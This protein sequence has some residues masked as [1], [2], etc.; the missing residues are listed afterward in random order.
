MD[1]KERIRE[2]LSLLPQSPGVYQFFNSQG[3]IIYIGKA[4]NLKRRVSSYFVKKPDTPKTAVLVRQIADIKYILVES[5]NDALLLE[6]NL[7]KRYQPRYNLMLKYGTTYPFLCITREEFPRVF[8]TRKVMAG[9][10]LYGPYSLIGN[11]VALLDLI[12]TLYPIRSCKLPLSEHSISQGRY[13]V[14]LEYHIKNCKGVCQGLQSREEYQAM[15]DDIRTIAKGN[16]HIVERYL[17]DKIK[18]TSSQMRFEEA[19]EWKQKYEAIKQFRQKTVISTQKEAT[20]DV[21]SCDSDEQSVYINMLRVV[22]GSIIQSNTIEYKKNIEEP[23]EEVFSS[24]IVEL[25]EQ[26][27][28]QAK[29]IVVPF[30]PEFSIDGV[31]FIVPKRDY[32]KE[33]LELSHKNV[34]QYKKDKYTQAEKLNSNQRQYA[35]MEQFRQLL[36]LPRMPHTIDIFDNSHTS[37]SQAVAACVV[38]KNLKPSKADYRKYIIREAPTAD[39]YASMQEVVRRRYRKMKEENSPLPDLIITDGGKGHISSVEEVLKSLEIEIPVAGLA[40]NDKHRTNELIFHGNTV[41]L[42]PTDILFKTLVGMQDEVHRFAIAFHRQ[43]RSQSQ[44]HS[45]LD[46]IAGIGEKSRI[47]LLQHFGSVEQIRG[48]SI[49]ELATIVGKARAKTVIEG[50]KSKN[51]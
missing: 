17:L 24:G 6:S 25:R 18:E 23:M 37:G 7:I 20:L 29:E 8:K 46:D 33:L 34:Q 41:S 48:A 39:D 47:A 27:H 43:K 12:K 38:F 2:I 22:N 30:L 49:D 26:Y 42:K 35:M 16:S 50:L 28:S 4:K 45:V 5:E 3:T 40:K 15:I 51:I 11:L 9:A 19:H 14:C 1:T 32:K 21:F 13:K 44:I 36:H 10:E 31:E